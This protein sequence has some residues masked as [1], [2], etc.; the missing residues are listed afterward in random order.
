MHFLGSSLTFMMVYIW[1]RRNPF[2]RMSF[3]GLFTFTAP[4]LPWVLLGFS[5]VLGNDAM[6]DSLGIA[7]GHL[8]YFVS[9]A[10]L[11]YR[12]RESTGR[13]AQ[14]KEMLVLAPAMRPRVLWKRVSLFRACD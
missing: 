12:E 2:V 8:Y 1:A 5:F 6:V 13:A 3:L 10:T 11:P 4:Y 14:R 9:F 7:I